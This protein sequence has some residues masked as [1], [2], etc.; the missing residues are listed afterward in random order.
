MTLIVMNKKQSTV[1]FS[2][3]PVK[4]GSGA[5]SKLSQAVLG[6]G[7]VSALN[8]NYSDAGLFC[9]TAAAPAGAAGKVVSAAAKALRS[10]KIDEAQLTRA[11]KQLKADILMAQESTSQL[12]EELSSVNR[13]VDLLEAINKVSLADVNAAAAHLASAK[14]AVAAV[15]NLA[16]VP[17]ADEL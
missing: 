13:G 5:G 8:I 3:N 12:L 9:F 15:G 1:S 7:A 17:F 11:K 4:Y 6:N 14:L 10:A 2:G 16:N